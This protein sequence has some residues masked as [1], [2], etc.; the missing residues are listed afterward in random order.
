MRMFVLCTITQQL[1]LR[2]VPVYFIQH[3]VYATCISIAEQLISPCY[4]YV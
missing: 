1:S 2:R 3:L 4:N